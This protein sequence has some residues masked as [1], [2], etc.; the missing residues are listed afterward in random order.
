M[1]LQ[2]PGWLKAGLVVLLVLLTACHRAATRQALAPDS[3]AIEHVTVI[4][5]ASGELHPDSTIVWNG[6]Q[7][8]QIGP[9]AKVSVREAARVIDG[10]HRFVIPGLW[11]MHSHSLW[12]EDAMQR[13]LPL[14]VAHGVTGIRDMGGRLD[15]LAAYREQR[16]KD[17]AALPDV[18]AAGQV[19]DGADPVSPEI[20]IAVP[21]RS[22]ASAAVATLQ[23][24]GADFIK[25][26]TLLEREPYFA[27]MQA[28]ARL[29]LNVVGHVP[30]SVTV[31][32]AVLAGQ[33]SIEHLRDELEPLVCTPEVAGDCKRMAALFREHRTWQVPTLVTLR[34]KA[35]FDD[36]ELVNDPR[37]RYLPPS[38]LAEWLAERE[39]KIARGT[40]YLQ[41]KQ[42][43]YHEEQAV[44]RMLVQEQVPIMA[45]SDAGVAF[46]Y[47]GSGLHE[48]LELLVEAGMTPL[49][50]LRAATL[51]PAQFLNRPGITGSIAVGARADLVLLRANPLTDIRATRD[52]EAVVLRGRW[53][54]RPALNELIGS[55][56]EPSQ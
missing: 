8:S 2:S 16:A 45:G 36:P 15:L 37:N 24:A 43:W 1:A 29:D 11:D 33:A 30:A 31:E 26:Y 50:A 14:Y 48:E 19:L 18:I 54:D 56:A 47:P 44:A 38:L 41:R 22:A 40:E 10:T 55:T 49:A 53:F 12:S 6:T 20:S 46:C 9:S 42:A 27:V 52:I 13:F 51:M 35:K 25:V 4:D 32:E 3:Y 17:A 39:A 28:A 21:D 34:S 23:R 7:I 5:V